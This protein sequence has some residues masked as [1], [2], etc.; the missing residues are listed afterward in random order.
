[1]IWHRRFVEKKP[2]PWTDDPI[3]A[4]HRFT[5]VYRELDRGTIF[6]HSLL[7][8][9]GKKLDEILFP[10]VL[11]R[12]INRP[13]FFEFCGF[14]FFYCNDDLELLRDYIKDYTKDGKPLF[15]TAYRVICNTK[16]GMSRSEELIKT[17][18]EFQ[19]NYWLAIAH[20]DRAE[21]YEEFNAELQSN[22]KHVGPFLAYEIATDLININPMLKK[23]F[24]EDDW[25]YIG[26]G[27]RVG[28]QYIYP[29]VDISS[30]ENNYLIGMAEVLRKEQA[31]YLPFKFPYYKEKKLSLR[32]IEH[33]LCE[34]GKYR[35][36]LSGKGRARPKFSPH[37]YDNPPIY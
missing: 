29:E 13:E 8:P 9:R 27:A 24:S 16:K 36:I 28:L 31:N 14:E 21:T 30:K 37:K 17:M 2:A 34:Y 6:L 15:N 11:Y 32:N 10:I 12:F 7:T 23:K 3:L 5:N 20:L 4:E 1:M 26:P 33:S 22:I 18:E 35:N 25:A 19:E